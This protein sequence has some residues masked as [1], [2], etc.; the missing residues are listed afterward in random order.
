MDG[1]IFDTERLSFDTFTQAAGELGWTASREA[2]LAGMGVPRAQIPKTLNE[3]LGRGFPALQVVDRSYELLE[4]LIDRDGPPMKDGVEAVLDALDDRGVRSV[5]ATSTDT[6]TARRYLRMAGIIGRFSGVIGGDQI[7][8]GKPH[9]DIFLHAAETLESRPQ[10]TLVF[11]D[12]EIGARAALAAE[13]RVV[14]IPDF[15]EP[16]DHVRERIFAVLP[17]LQE[18]ARQID[19]LLA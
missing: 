12:S 5:V 8:Q 1:L 7:E 19:S 17:S 6:E 3:V 2:F 18:A 11:E 13:S 10:A 4:E 15:T 14:V 16:S 9:P